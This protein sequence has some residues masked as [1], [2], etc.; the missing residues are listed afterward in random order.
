M[1]DFFTAMR[2]AGSGLTAQRSRM[3]VVASNLANASTTHTAEG[4]PYRRK[5]PVFRA[6]PLPERF[7]ARVDDVLGE[8]VHQ[9]QVDSVVQDTSPPRRVYDP[10][11]PDADADG[12]VAYPNIEIVEEMVNMI[13]AS[14]S[15]AAN[16]SVLDTVKQMAAR[17]IDLLR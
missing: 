9:V 5:D 12:Y 2:I 7:P 15:Y 1:S 10:D 3:N 13:T 4:G 11:H 17:A 8:N 14:R 6:I 16:A